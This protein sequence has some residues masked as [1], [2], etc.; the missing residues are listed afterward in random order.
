[1]FVFTTNTGSFFLHALFIALH[2]EH[3][4]TAFFIRFLELRL[5]MNVSSFN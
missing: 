5:L 3:E 1:M 4:P 2:P